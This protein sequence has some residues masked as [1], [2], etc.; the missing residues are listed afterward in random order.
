[1]AEVKPS[2]VHDILGSHILADGYSIV[3]DLQR[4]TPFTIYDSREGREYLDFFTFFASAPFG[5][6]HPGMNNPEFIEKIGKAAVNKPSNSDLYTVEMAEMVQTMSRVAIPGYLPH[7]FLISGGALAVENALKVAF[8]WKV[9]KNLE[10]GKGEIG[11]QVIHFKHAFHGRS[12]YTLS[13]TNTAD[14]RKYKYFPMFKWP[15]IDPPELTF[16][17][18]EKAARTADER[19][20]Q[21]VEKA[22]TDNPDDIAAVIIEPIMAE[23]GDKHLT[24]YFLQGLKQLCDRH[25][26]VFILDE[27]QTGIALTG[28][29]WCHQAFDVIPDIIAFGK[30]SQVCGILAGPKIDEVALNCFS[31]SSRINSTFGG[32]LVDMVRFTRILEIIEDEN[33]VENARQ[34]GTYLLD[35]LVELQGEY[36]S[37]SNARGRGLMC[38]FDLPDDTA[39]ETFLNDALAEGILILGC[40]TR[41]VRFRPPLQT[42]REHVDN[43][44]E[45]I[46]K[47]LGK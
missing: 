30:K 34:V 43:G 5:A 13:L 41:S 28:E 36:P 16:P 39:R 22:F 4:S 26:A 10:K 40:G 6:N 35:R 3:L 15:R 19:A 37:V 38:A 23:G 20:L 42:T 2:E 17:V 7:L 46:E 32:N 18:N 24:A 1:M 9:R 11:S 31:E 21:A 44:I 12:G 14:P 47:I 33:L 29:M 25:E 8:D 27:V 45:V